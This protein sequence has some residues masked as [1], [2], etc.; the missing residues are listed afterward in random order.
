MSQTFDEMI[1]GTNTDPAPQQ[2]PGKPITD[3]S[4]RVVQLARAIDRLPAGAYEIEIVKPD[5]RAQDWDVKIV[6]T[7]QIQHLTL[8]KNTY[9]PE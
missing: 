2:D 4:P 3:L 7:E 9:H 6:R 8:P 1:T 5:V